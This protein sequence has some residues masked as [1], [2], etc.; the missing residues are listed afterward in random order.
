MYA[1]LGTTQ[2]TRCSAFT[3]CTLPP[4]VRRDVVTAAL[5]EVDLKVQGMTCGHCTSAVQKALEGAPKVDSVL[6]VSLD[7][8]VA[9]VNVDCEDQMAALQALPALLDA[10]KKVGFEAEPYFGDAGGLDTQRKCTLRR[11]L[12]FG[13][14]TAYS[15][16]D[17][18]KQIDL[19]CTCCHFCICVDAA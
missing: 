5:V 1:R 7:T 17:K 10:V 4:L 8:G 2:H 13:Y 14:C 15:E 12:K 16:L 9:S 11:C 6:D 3:R 19:Q 18:L